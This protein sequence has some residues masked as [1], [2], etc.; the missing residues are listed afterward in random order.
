MAGRKADLIVPVRVWVVAVRPDRA[1][2]AVPPVCG[3]Y[4]DFIDV[5]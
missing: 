4:T 2:W 1:N 5:P 3:S